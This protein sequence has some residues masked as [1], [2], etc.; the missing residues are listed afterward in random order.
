MIAEPDKASPVGSSVGIAGV[1]ETEV[2][3]VLCHVMVAV[4]ADPT[5]CGEMLNAIVGVVPAPTTVTVIDEVEEFPA[6][7]V[8]VAV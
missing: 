6:E 2:A 4:C 1:I 3:L 7:S 5:T 8:A